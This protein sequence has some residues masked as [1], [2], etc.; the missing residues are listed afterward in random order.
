MM[1]RHAVESFAE[2]E[3]EVKGKVYRANGLFGGAAIVLTVKCRTKKWN[4][5]R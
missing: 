2:V 4:C 3:F 1:S 5:P